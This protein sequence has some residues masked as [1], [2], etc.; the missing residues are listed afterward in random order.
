M[1]SMD[2]D[3][4]T[5]IMNKVVDFFYGR[6]SDFSDP[7]DV[8]T[9]RIIN[10]LNPSP[11]NVTLLI[12]LDIY[13]WNEMLKDID[14]ILDIGFTREQVV[15]EMAKYAIYDICNN[16]IVDD[17]RLNAEILKQMISYMTVSNYYVIALIN[18]QI[19]NGT[20]TDDDVVELCSLVGWV[21][22]S[23]NEFV[24]HINK[25]IVDCVPNITPEMIRLAYITPTYTKGFRGIYESL[26][27]S[28][29]NLDGSPLYKYN[30]YTTP[31]VYERDF[32]MVLGEKHRLRE[33][34]KDADEFNAIL[35]RDKQIK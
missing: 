34:F 4:R 20:V 13:K 10:M 31:Y 33:V 16:D 21:Y 3:C 35:E 18:M 15:D 8:N 11:T 27:H 30:H 28:G 9:V 23:T 19:R 1:F 22:M 32:I 25:K 7:I 12:S 29:T 2:I 26:T 14:S 5:N 24:T 17:M 6:I